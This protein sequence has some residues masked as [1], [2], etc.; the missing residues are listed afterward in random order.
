MQ[1]IAEWLASLGMSDIRDCCLE[2]DYFNTLPSQRV[3]GVEDVAFDQ[4]IGELLRGRLDDV[5]D[6]V[7][8][9]QRDGSPREMA[10]GARVV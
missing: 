8:K 1:S 2:P 5:V 6:L 10:R 3:S 7:L 9:A 4:G